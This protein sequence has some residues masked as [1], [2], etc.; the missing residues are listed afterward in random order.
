MTSSPWFGNFAPVDKIPIAGR[1]IP[2]YVFR[3]D[4]I[5]SRPGKEASGRYQTSANKQTRYRRTVDIGGS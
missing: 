3:L 1:E 5:V 4:V 2:D